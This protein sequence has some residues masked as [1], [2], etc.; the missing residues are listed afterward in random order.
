MSVHCKK[1]QCL[2]SESKDMFG[3][4]YV[5]KNWMGG[6]WKM[7]RNGTQIQKSNTLD[8]MKVASN[9]LCVRS[10]KNMFGKQLF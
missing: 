5:Y 6:I 9:N 7:F 8:K 3:K 1:K 2:E 10:D 4:C